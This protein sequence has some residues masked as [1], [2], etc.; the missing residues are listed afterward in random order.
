MLIN[1]LRLYKKI[2]YGTL[3]EGLPELGFNQ[4]AWVMHFNQKLKGTNHKDNPNFTLDDMQH[5]RRD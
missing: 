5:F 1:I 2:H 4:V 3:A